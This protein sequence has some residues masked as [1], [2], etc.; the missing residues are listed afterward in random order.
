M[1]NDAAKGGAMKRSLST[2][3]FLAIVLLGCGL[4]TKATQGGTTQPGTTVKAGVTN[5]PGATQEPTK[6]A[7]LPA[8]TNTACNELSFYLNPDLASKIKCETVPESGG[9]DAM[10]FNTNPQ[11]TK[12]SLVGYPLTGRMMQPV[13]SVFPVQRYTELLPDV[14]NP[15]VSALQALIA[16]GAPSSSDIPILPVQNARQLFLAQ[17]AVLQF[18][19]GSGVGYVTQYAQAYVPINNHELFFSFQGLTS[20]GAYWISIILPISHPSLWET[21]GDP[22]NSIWT[23]INDNPDAYYSQ[24]AADLNE[25]LPRSYVPTILLLDALIKSITIQP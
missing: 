7:T 4:L 13:I 23:T 3:A 17:F 16:G 15:D 9:A 21:E 10:P 8:A 19:N 11:Y 24:M 25:K 18:Q 22:T 1:Y 2:F 14:V 5:K 12:V 6:K 20:D